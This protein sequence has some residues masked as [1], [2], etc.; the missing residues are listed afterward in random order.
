MISELLYSLL[1]FSCLLSLDSLA[2][3]NESV[4]NQ[5]KVDK[6]SVLSPKDPTKVETTELRLLFIQYEDRMGGTAPDLGITVVKVDIYQSS[7]D[8]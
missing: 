8:K 5:F 7:I 1:C 3:L 2:S 6:T 4:H